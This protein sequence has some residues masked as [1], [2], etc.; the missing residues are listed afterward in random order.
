ML[1]DATPP[2]NQQ[3]A[4]AARDYARVERAIDFLISNRE[5]QPS[6][7]AVAEHVG[8]SAFHV[9]RLFTRWAGI[10]PKKFLSYLTIEHAKQRLEQSESV[11]DAAYDAGLSG[12]SR[13]HDLM[14]SAEAMTPGEYKAMG[15]DL[16]IRHGVAP[17]P[18]GEALFL[19]SDRGLCGLEFIDA[20]PDVL[21]TEAKERWPLSQFVEDQSTAQTTTRT[22]FGT[23]EA[24]PI[25]MK[26]TPWQLQV[27][28]ALLRIPTGS[29][30]SYGQ[31]ADLVCT[32]QASRAVGTAVAANH[33]GYV[34]PCHRVLR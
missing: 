27:W 34:V 15:S 8:L 7:D 19:V 11:L 20:A 31:I 33:I 12:S 1:K 4:D 2:P 23:G 17:T 6:L 16:T 3:S 9:Q 14:V 28:S 18:Y 30:V 21:L 24:I 5:S 32:R 13:L 25:L 26:G 22:V 29:I 10:S